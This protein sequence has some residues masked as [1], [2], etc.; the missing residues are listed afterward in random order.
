[1]EGESRLRKSMLISLY[2]WPRNHHQK[3][4]AFHASI[5]RMLTSVLS[6]CDLTIS[7]IS[8]PSCLHAMGISAP[9]KLDDRR[10]KK[11][12]QYSF[13]LPTWEEHLTAKS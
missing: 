7:P 4:M 12:R 9:P 3:E 8:A 1:M 6:V 10:G 5:P 2:L 11:S 13:G